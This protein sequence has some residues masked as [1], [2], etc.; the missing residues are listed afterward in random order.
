[1]CVQQQC[2]N[3]ASACSINTNVTLLCY[4]VDMPVSRGGTL[5]ATRKKNRKITQYRVE[6]SMN[7]E[8]AWMDKT[9][10]RNEEGKISE[11][12]HEKHCNTENPNVPLFQLVN[13]FFQ[14][15]WLTSFVITLLSRLNNIVDNSEPFWSMHAARVSMRNRSYS[16]YRTFPY[17]VFIHQHIAWMKFP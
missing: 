9:E 14:Q 5:G 13:T 16:T 1:M 15:W 3:D 11:I 2:R 17:A 4:G 10:Y 12:P 6:N 8:T 7:T